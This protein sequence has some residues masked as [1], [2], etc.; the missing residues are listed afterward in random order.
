METKPVAIFGYEL[1][2]PKFTGKSYDL[3][4]FDF[5]CLEFFFKRIIQDIPL[6]E[7]AFKE[8]N[9]MINLIS[10]KQ[11]EDANIYE[12]VFI[13]ARYGKE[14]EIIDIFEQVEAGIK[15]KNH[16]VKNEINFV[17]DKRTG[18]LLLEKDSENVARKTFIKKFFRYHRGLIDDYLV[19]FNKKYDPVKMHRTNFLKISSLPSK[20]FFEE[21]K[22]FSVINDAYYYL[23]TDQ[24]E[25]KSNEA[26]N[27]LYL[28]NNAKQNG[29]KGISRV[30]VSFE[31]TIPKD[32][33]IG[34]EQ[35]FKK[36]FEEQHFD[37]IGIQGKTHS[38]RSRTIEL[39]NIQRVFDIKVNHNEN[40][41]PSLK[42]LT[43]GMAE[44]ILKDNPVA[45]KRKIDQFEGVEI[46]GDEKEE[47]II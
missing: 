24:L 35:Y 12:G 28:Y 31:N 5:E 1:T 15:P 21:L 4:R 40:G 33:V 25:S 9:K 18:L 6:K 26:A 23:D 13:T 27:V 2:T 32:S 46:D 34:V 3:D 38:G 20:T 14:Q 19:A 47:R 7:R 11:S 36:L 44:I 17:V 37:G 43:E 16:G 39:E 22:Q 30:K 10:F 45:Y 42:D 8:D 29:M 41:M